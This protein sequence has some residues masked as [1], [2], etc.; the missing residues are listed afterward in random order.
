M[1]FNVV[2]VNC[3]KYASTVVELSF[4]DTVANWELTHEHC[5]NVRF[6][7]SGAFKDGGEWKE[8]RTYALWAGAGINTVTHYRPKDSAIPAPHSGK[9]V[10]SFT[11]PTDYAGASC[12]GSTEDGGNNGEGNGGECDTQCQLED[13]ADA[14]PLDPPK[15]CYLDTLTYS[16]GN[17]TDQWKYLMYSGGC[18]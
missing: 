3:P 13:W 1:M 5:A 9:L 4:T 7:T 2:A 12:A 17:P 6:F 18:D 16:T 11:M 8:T 10:T 15:P 14:Y